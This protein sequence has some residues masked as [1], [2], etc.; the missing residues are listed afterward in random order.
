MN[1]SELLAELFLMP[2]VAFVVGLLMVLMMK[3]SAR[4]QRRIGPPFFQPIYDIIQTVWKDTK[5]RTV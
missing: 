4:L 2:L 1:Y 3:I 5:F